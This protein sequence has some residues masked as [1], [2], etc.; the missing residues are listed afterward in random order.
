MAAVQGVV[1]V[2]AAAEVLPTVWAQVLLAVA[3]VLL[4]ESFG[5]QV[6]TLWRHRHEQP[7]PRS[8]LVRPVLDAVALAVVWLALVLPQRPDQLTAAALL[9]IPV[10]LLVFLAARAGAAAG[11][12]PRAGGRS[13]ACCWPSPSS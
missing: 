13:A 6:V 4:L 3:L 9:G 5:R 12:G 7:V 8:P 1:L 2:V 10:E 11:L